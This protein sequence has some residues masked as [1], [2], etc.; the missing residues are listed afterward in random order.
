MTLEKKFVYANLNIDGDQLHDTNYLV[1]STNDEVSSVS[2][3]AKVEINS[4]MKTT[5]KLYHAHNGTIL[6]QK[7]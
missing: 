2:E 3:R 5:T 7:T 6:N 4:R 1:V